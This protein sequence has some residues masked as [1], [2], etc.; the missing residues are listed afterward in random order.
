M[1]LNANMIQPSEHSNDEHENE[2]FAQ[3][4][5]SPIKTVK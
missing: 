5:L 2:S 1:E 4:K 3:K